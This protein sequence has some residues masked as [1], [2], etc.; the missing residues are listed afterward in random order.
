MHVFFSLAI[1]FRY[2]CGIWN[3]TFG[4]SLFTHVTHVSHIN[5][6]ADQEENDIQ[7]AI[8]KNDLDFIKYIVE[9]GIC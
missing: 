9:V 1:C 6:K 4:A 8:S 5:D 7:L 3:R 2:N